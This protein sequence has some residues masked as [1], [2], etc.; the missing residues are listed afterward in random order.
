MDAVRFYTREAGGRVA[1]R[2]LNE[3]ERV[4]LLLEEFP[5][6]GRTTNDQ[7]RS[8]P[9]SGFPYSVIYRHVNADIRVLVVR[10]QRRDPIHGGHRR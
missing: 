8:Y 10:H 1:A 5:E 4:L 6:I 3:F 7:R 2:F 9:L